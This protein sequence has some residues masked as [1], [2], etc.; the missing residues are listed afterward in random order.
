MPILS[1]SPFSVEE[2][3]FPTGTSHFGRATPL[4]KRTG[5]HKMSSSLSITVL[6]LQ[7]RGSIVV[8]VVLRPR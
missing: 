2:R 7:I 3:I 8:V 1:L 6:E 4:Q 5:S